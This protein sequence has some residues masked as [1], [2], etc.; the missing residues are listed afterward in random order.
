MNKYSFLRKPHTRHRLWGAMLLAASLALCLVSGTSFL[1]MHRVDRIFPSEDLSKK[2]RLSDYYAPLQGSPGDTDIFIFEGEK[3]GG[4]LLILG[5]THPNEPAGFIAAV[6]LVE[7]SLVEQGKVVIIPQANLSGFTHNDPFEG[8]PQRFPIETPGGTRW[9]RYGSRLTNPVHQWPDPALYINPSGQRL[10]GSEARNLN[11]NYPGRSR[12]GGLTL[13][14]AHAIMELMRQE[15]IDVAV[16]LHEAAP[17][18]PVINALV[19]HDRSAELAAM[20]LMELQLNGLDF[21]LEESPVNLRGLSHREWGDLGFHAFLFESANASHGRLKGRPSMDLITEGRDENYVKAAQ[22]KRLFVPFDEQGIPLAL[23][24]ARH[25]AAV[26]ALLTSWAELF[27]E[28]SISASDW[29]AAAALINQGI[30]PFLHA[31]H[32]ISGSGS[33]GAPRPLK[34]ALGFSPQSHHEP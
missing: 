11:R 9:F 7:N 3:P 21:R 32:R 20:T 10:A 18:Y 4:S 8:N 2:S 13:N 19:F 17:E 22:L 27:P 29:P 25:V 14:I 1:S 5:G 28:R 30:G 12:G 24:V 6:L 31:P 26:Q 23:R 16:D 34:S 15:Q 33:T